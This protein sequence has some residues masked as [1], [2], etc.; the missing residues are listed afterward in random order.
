VEAITAVERPVNDLI[1]FLRARLDEDERSA[2]A[3][4]ERGMSVWEA[5]EQGRVAMV[6]LPDGDA[7]IYDEG[8]PNDDQ[9]RHIARWDPARVLA[10]VQAK[11][12]IVDE[13][14]PEMETVE[15][16][17]RKL[18]GLLATSYADHPDYDL[19]WVVEAVTP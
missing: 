8:S 6:S 9:A 7:L 10:E 15:Y 14:V 4:I 18:L 17:S 2:R 19:A 3:A 16:Q 11:R 1:E 5:H 13:V 12:R